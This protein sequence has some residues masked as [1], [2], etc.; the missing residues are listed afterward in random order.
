MGLKENFSQAVK[1]LTGNTKEDDKK[2]NAQVAGLKKALDNAPSLSG[3][4]RF[5]EGTGRPYYR[6]EAD[7]YNDRGDV[8]RQ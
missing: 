3:N 4:D 2:R 1:E 7:Q 6:D 5:T 8:Y